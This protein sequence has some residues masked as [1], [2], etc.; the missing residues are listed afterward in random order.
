MLAV[1]FMGWLLRKLGFDM[2]PIILGFVLGQVMEVNLRNALAISGGD[3][4]ILFQ[5]HISLVLWALAILVA[6][7]PWLLYS[8]KR[9]ARLG[10]GSFAHPPDCASCRVRSWMATVSSITRP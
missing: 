4:G 10:V 3:L 1:G 8:S 6:V 7:G 5:S 2:A 9:A